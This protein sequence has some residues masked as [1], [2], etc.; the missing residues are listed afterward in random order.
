ME[1][2]EKM[3]LTQLK[4]DYLSYW[5]SIYNLEVYGS[6]DVQILNMLGA[7][8]EQ[9]GYEVIHVPKIVKA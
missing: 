4:Q 6:H 2:V 7:E 1:E 3:S 5:D 9:R 8:L